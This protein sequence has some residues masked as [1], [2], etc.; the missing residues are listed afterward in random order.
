MDRFCGMPSYTD[1][2]LNRM[3]SISRDLF[4]SYQPFELCNLEY[5]DDRLSSIEMHCDDT[6]IWGERLIWFVS[7]FLFHAEASYPWLGF[8]HSF[9]FK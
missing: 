9:F 1:L 5:S 3:N 2:I 8:C 6:W 4:G 7:G